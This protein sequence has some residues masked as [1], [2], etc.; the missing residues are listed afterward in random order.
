M[1]SGERVEEGGGS[2]PVGGDCCRPR[3]IELDGRYIRGHGIHFAVDEAL[4]HGETYDDG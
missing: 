2:G 1:G 4:V 3:V